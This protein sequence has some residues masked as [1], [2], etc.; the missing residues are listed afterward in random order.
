MIIKEKGIAMSYDLVV[1]EKSIAPASKAEF[2][3]WS[4]EQVE[5][6]EDHAYDSIEVRSSKLKSWFLDMI[7]LFPPMNGDFDMD[8][9]LENDQ[10]L[11]SRFTD[12]SIGKNL[13]YAGFAW[14]QAETAYNTMLMLALKHDVGFFD[15]S[16]TGAIILS[17]TIKL[18]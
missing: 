10:E 5:W 9:A 16:G 14:S 7:K 3:E 8:D 11:E 18:D 13:I 6:K 12:Y 15:V 17:E 4:E 2:L 1:F